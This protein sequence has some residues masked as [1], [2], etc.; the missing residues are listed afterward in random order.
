MHVFLWN[1]Y[2]NQN[3]ITQGGL[4]PESSVIARGQ[5]LK[6]CNTKNTEW[7]WY[8]TS[9]SYSNGQDVFVEH[10]KIIF[11]QN[12]EVGNFGL[13]GVPRK[14]VKAWVYDAH[15]VHHF[16]E[17]VTVKNILLYRLLQ[18]ES[19]RYMLHPIWVLSER[20][21]HRTQV[22][23]AVMAIAVHHARLERKLDAAC[24]ETTHSSTSCNNPEASQILALT[25]LRGTQLFS[26]L[27]RSVQLRWKNGNSRS[28]ATS[29]R[30][31][32]IITFC[33]C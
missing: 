18:S 7:N 4:G 30:C 5:T 10:F 6:A 23:I 1:Y 3:I 17:Y 20:R 29:Q 8:L 28:K 15:R 19:C 22:E 27:P 31:A 2:T 33:A 11:G 24:L 16:T 25:L 21:A 9:Y 12:C 13:L 32:S 26:S 14:S